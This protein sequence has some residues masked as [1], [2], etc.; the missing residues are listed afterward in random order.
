M[1]RRPKTTRELKHAE[2]I[3]GRLRK[4]REA[5]GLSQAEL[6]RRL[7][8]RSQNAVTAYETGR[9]QLPLS[10]VVQACRALNVRIE[11]LLEG[12]EPR[13]AADFEK[14]QIE[15]YRS[16]VYEGLRICLLGETAA[17]QNDPNIPAHLKTAYQQAARYLQQIPP[18]ALDQAALVR[19]IRQLLLQV[20]SQEEQLRKADQTPRRPEREKD[21]TRKKK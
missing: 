3:G 2:S 17:V 13:A 15:K 20:Q 12:S 11:W 4:A 1:P 7:G 19:S 8:G 14:E 6:G 9:S 21:K 10:L 16:S 5:A 18:E